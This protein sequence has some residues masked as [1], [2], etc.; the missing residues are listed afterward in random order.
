MSRNLDNASLVAEAWKNAMEEVHKKIEELD[1]S[2]KKDKNFFKYQEERRKWEQ[3][4]NDCSEMYL[5]AIKDAL[6]V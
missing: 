5:V 4:Y 2:D 6:G 3:T 1:A